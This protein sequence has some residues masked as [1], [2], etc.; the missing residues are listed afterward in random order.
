[1]LFLSL[2]ASATS[3]LGRAA[4]SWA[5]IMRS[6]AQDVGFAT[7]GS[8]QTSLQVFVERLRG[9]AAAP[10]NFGRIPAAARPKH[11][12]THTHAGRDTVVDVDEPFVTSG[13]F[14]FYDPETGRVEAFMCICVRSRATRRGSSASTGASPACARAAPLQ[15]R[16]LL[17]DGFPARQGTHSACALSKSSAPPSHSGRTWSTWKLASSVTPQAAHTHPWRAPTWR[18]CSAVKVRQAISPFPEKRK[19][20]R[21]N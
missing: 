7:F 9:P 19:R 13:F 14:G 11:T 17:L 15:P 4:I 8:F 5:S 3:T 20:E 10:L 16:H 21:E 12:H 1:M 2:R 18:L 6:S